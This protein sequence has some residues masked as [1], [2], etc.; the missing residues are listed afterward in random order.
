M[1]N[2]NL[3]NKFV[4]Y[5]PTK[6]RKEISQKI[7]QRIRQKDCQKKL[8]KKIVIGIHTIGTKVTQKLKNSKKMLGKSKTEEISD[9][10]SFASP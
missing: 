5:L 1:V 8:S 3:Q 6:H 4:K 10:R 2:K 7:H 9:L